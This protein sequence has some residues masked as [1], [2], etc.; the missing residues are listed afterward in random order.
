MSYIVLSGCLS[1]VHVHAAQNRCALQTLPQHA[2]QQHRAS[3]VL[4]EP[5]ATRPLTYCGGGVVNGKASLSRPGPRLLM[6]RARKL[7]GVSYGN[8]FA[9]VKRSC[10][11]GGRERGKFGQAGAALLLSAMFREMSHLPSLWQRQR[12]VDE[13]QSSPGH[14]QSQCRRLPPQKSLLHW[15][16]CPE[17][18]RQ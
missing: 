2:P 7:T 18:R 15:S 8:A 10:G 4:I 1:H 14:P 13:Q 12:S 5:S 9:K 6:A 3:A 11:Q 16:S 17:P